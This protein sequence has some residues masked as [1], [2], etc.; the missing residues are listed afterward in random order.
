MRLL[1]VGIVAL[2]AACGGSAANSERVL[3]LRTGDY[4]E[5]Q[6]RAEIRSDGLSEA[7][8]QALKGLDAKAVVDILDVQFAKNAK[9]DDAL[10]PM[11][12]PRRVDDLRQGE[13][14]LE[15]CQRLY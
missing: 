1:I 5:A 10:K 7:Q 15:E 12:T 11:Q 4:T 6:L 8:C 2:G 13:I 14:I 3:H 9:T